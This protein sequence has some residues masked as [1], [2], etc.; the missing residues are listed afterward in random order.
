[1]IELYFTK[2]STAR[3]EIIVKIKDN[4][5]FKKKYREFYG[6]KP[7]KIDFWELQNSFFDDCVEVEYEHPLWEDEYIEND[8]ELIEK[9][10]EIFQEAVSLNNLATLLSKRLE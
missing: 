5:L 4:E 3:Q 6:K 8:Y 1:M 7:S 2:H 10:K 9:Y